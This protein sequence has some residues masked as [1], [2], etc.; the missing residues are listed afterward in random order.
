MKTDFS[1]RPVYLQNENRIKA[2][3]LICFLA[4]LFYRIL[5]RKLDYRYTCDEILHTL[6]SMN[7][8]DLL[9]FQNLFRVISHIHYQTNHRKNYLNN[10]LCKD[11]SVQLKEIV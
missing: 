7:F 4:L 1:A 5:E 11:Y 8:A 2:H 9:Y 3:F 6:K 10:K